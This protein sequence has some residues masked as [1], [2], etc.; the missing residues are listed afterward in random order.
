MIG[1]RADPNPSAEVVPRSSGTTSTRTARSSTTM[2]LSSFFSSFLPT[3]YADAPAEEPKE[4]QKEEA[5]A[6]EEEA[7]EEPA[8]EE[9]EEEEEPE[10][11]RARF[12]AWQGACTYCLFY[13]LCPPSV[14]SARTLLSV[15]PLPSTSSTARI[16]ST[17]ERASTA[18]TA[19]R[20][21]TSLS[22]ET[23]LTK[24]L[25]CLCSCTC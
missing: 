24:V 22:F 10:D 20:N 14:R 5:P 2:S 12:A 7:A 19:L 23:F 18:R 25:T 1:E 15:H 17:L 4:E 3:V 16:V 13:S 21:C 8:A 9:E 6:Q 11:V